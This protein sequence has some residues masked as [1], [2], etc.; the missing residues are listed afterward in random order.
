MQVDITQKQCV[1]AQ[2]ALRQLEKAQAGSSDLQSQLDRLQQ[3]LHSQQ[4]FVTSLEATI[5]GTNPGD[6]SHNSNNNKVHKKI[7][8][9]NLVVKFQ[10]VNWTYPRLL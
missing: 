8:E 9:K 2:Q 1:Q 4:Q 3:N 5:A 10:M 7:A 6:T